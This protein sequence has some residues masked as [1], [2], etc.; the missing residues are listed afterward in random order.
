MGPYSQVIRGPAVGVSAAPT[1]LMAN[2]VGTQTVELDWMASAGTIVGY[3]IERSTDAGT[4]WVTA[5]ANTRNDNEYYS[6]THSSL[7]GKSVVYRVAAINSVGMG[8]SSANS[9]SETLPKAGTQPGAP[10]AFKATVSATDFTMVSLSWDAPSSQG[11]SAIDWLQCST[12][13]KRRALLDEY[14]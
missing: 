5:N 12:V 1:G 9:A 6:D 11:A 10:R 3:K 14:Y 8:P 4:T 2:A 7:A 13:G